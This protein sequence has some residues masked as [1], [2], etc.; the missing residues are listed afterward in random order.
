M[1]VHQLRSYIDSFQFLQ[2]KMQERD[3]IIFE[4]NH[5]FTTL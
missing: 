1:R 5:I 4:F 3:V 2:L